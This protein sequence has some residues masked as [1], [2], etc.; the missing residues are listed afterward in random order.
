MPHPSPIGSR[1]SFHRQSIIAKYLYIAE[2]N[3]L[4]RHQV[5]IMHHAL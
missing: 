2:N 5:P 3:G 4:L 1:I